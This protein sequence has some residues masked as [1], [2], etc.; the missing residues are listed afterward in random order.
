M[1]VTRAKG[2]T[3]AT[4]KKGAAVRRNTAAP[5]GDS[6]HAVFLANLAENCNVSEAARAAGIHRRTAYTHRD[7][8]SAFAADWDAAVEDGV[9]LLEAEARRRAL[10]GTVKPVF[11]Q[12]EE[13][14]GVREYSDTLMIFLLKAHRP[15]RF[16]DNVKVEHEGDLGVTVRYSDDW[17]N[18]GG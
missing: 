8:D 16:R 12:G 6:W 2:A 4:P 1:A 15:E 17:R 10:K 7:Q 5:K 9:D 13:C 3:G 11:Y 18:E 14:G